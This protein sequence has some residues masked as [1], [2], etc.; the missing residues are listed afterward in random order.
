MRIGQYY[1][2]GQYRVNESFLEFDTRSIPANATISSVSLVLT[3]CVDN[4]A[5]LTAYVYSKDYGPTL[6]TADHVTGGNLAGLVRVATFNMNSWNGAGANTFTSDAAFISKVVKA[7]YTRL[8]VVDYNMVAGTNP[9]A[10]NHYGDFRSPWYAT[11]ASR[12]KLVVNYT[13]SSDVLVTMTATVMLR[14]PT[15]E[16]VGCIIPAQPMRANVIYDGGLVKGAVNSDIDGFIIYVH[17][18]NTAAGYTFGE[19]PDNE[20]MHYV[21]ADTRD[22]KLYGLPADK[23]Y[24][25]GVRSYRMVDNDIAPTG[26]LMSDIVQVPTD[27]NTGFLQ[28]QSLCSREP[29]NQVSLL[30]HQSI[31]E[32]CSQ[33]QNVWGSG[34]VLICHGEH[35][36]IVL[37]TCT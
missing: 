28:T 36:S 26:V 37:G 5:G 13:T 9:G 29:S 27:G 16:I 6:T 12:P 35:T 30:L 2:G 11:V 10:G 22:Y 34:M 17:Q 4:A 24:H 31:G 33:T 7:G 15:I 19:D 3:G 20:H 23:Y 32:G 21:N 8:L 14:T 18:S 25:L 1:S